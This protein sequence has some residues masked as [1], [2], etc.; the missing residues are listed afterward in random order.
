MVWGSLLLQQ[1]STH[2]REMVITPKAPTSLFL[3]LQ[4]RS[5]TPREQI[6]NAQG[7]NLRFNLSLPS[8]ASSLAESAS[9]EEWSSLRSRL[10]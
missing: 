7:V 1:R 2:P 3:L 8:E 4:Q 6:Y 10:V 5:N 9:A